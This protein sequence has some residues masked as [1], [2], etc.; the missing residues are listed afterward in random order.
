MQAATLKQI[1]AYLVLVAAVT[2]NRMLGYD[3]Y[4]ALY[5][6]LVL[7]TRLMSDIRET[8]RFFPYRFVLDRNILRNQWFLWWT[9]YAMWHVVGYFDRSDY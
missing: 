7:P 5:F 6:V 4:I 3:L 8:Q 9:G 1:Y 2:F